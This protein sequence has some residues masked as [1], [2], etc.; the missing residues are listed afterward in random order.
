VPA[1]QGY[2]REDQPGR[3][4]PRNRP[5][6]DGGR[7]G[8]PRGSRRRRHGAKGQEPPPA[9]RGQVSCH[10]AAPSPRCTI[11]G[12]DA[13]TGGPPTPRAALVGVLVTLPMLGP[14]YGRSDDKQQLAE[15][16]NRFRSTLTVDGK[17]LLDFFH[18]LTLSEA[19]QERIRGLIKQLDEAGYKDR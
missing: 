10:V 2:R 3:A 11:Q 5:A 1:R 4:A 7:R 17:V 13:P 19:D 15:D 18:R 14:P 16:E 6:A 12:P 9:R 8:R